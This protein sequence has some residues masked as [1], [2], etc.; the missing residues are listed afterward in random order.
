MVAGL[1]KISLHS[2]GEFRFGLPTGS[3]VYYP[4][5]DTDTDGGEEEVPFGLVCLRVGSDGECRCCAA[6]GCD[7]VS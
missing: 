7:V 1:V 2:V 3:A 6:D 5:A 4:E